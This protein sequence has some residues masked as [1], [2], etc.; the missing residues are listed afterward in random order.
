M[1]FSFGSV[2]NAMGD[3]SSA[4]AGGLTEGPKLEVIQ[5]EVGMSP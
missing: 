1:A 2:D 3:N 5:T 4:G